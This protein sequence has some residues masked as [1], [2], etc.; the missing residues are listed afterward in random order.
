MILPILTVRQAATVGSVSA[1]C[2]SAAG[3]VSDTDVVRL[4]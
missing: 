1:A 3:S 2:S 4:T